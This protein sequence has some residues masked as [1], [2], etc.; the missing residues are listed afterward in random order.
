MDMTVRGYA[1]NKVEYTGITVGNEH[2]YS[3]GQS[4]TGRK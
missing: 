4:H 1:D 3:T 2:E